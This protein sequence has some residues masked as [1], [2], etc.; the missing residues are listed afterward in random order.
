MTVIAN[1]RYAYRQLCRTPGFAAVALATLAICIGANLAIFSIVDAI[2]LRPLPF[3]APDRLIVI[4][5]SYPLGGVERGYNSIANYF[6]RRAAIKAFASLAIYRDDN[7][8]VGASGTPK[9]VPTMRVSSE[10]FSMLGTPL[11]MGRSFT[12]AE[13]SLGSDQVVVITDSFWR[14]HFGN[15]PKVLGRSFLNDGIPVT[16]VGVLRPDFRFLS[17]TPEFYRP[18]SYAPEDRH[19]DRRHYNRWNMIARLAPSA[20]IADA[21]AQINAL[22]I[23]QT[24]DDA[25]IKGVGYR[26]TVSP[27]HKDHVSAVR[28]TLVMLQCGCVFLLLIGLINLANLLLVR[29]SGR[30]Q[31]MA[32]RQTLG[33]SWR[34]IAAQVAVETIG[35][36]LAGAIL[37]IFLG[38]FGINLIRLLGTDQLP[39][40]RLITFD[41]HIVIVAL[42]AAAVVGLGLAIPV[43]WFALHSP[44]GLRL[45][46]T[47]G[48]TADRAAQSL[49]HGFIVVQIAL[50]FVLLSGAGLLGLTLK[51]LLETPLGFRAE[52]I[53]TGQIVLPQKNYS[54]DGARHAFVERLLPELRALPGVTEVAISTGLP[55]TNGGSYMG[56]AVE[57]DST[58]SGKPLHA[59]YL[60]GVSGEYWRTM[61]I[62]L[63]VG[64]ALEDTEDV[65]KPKVCVVDQSVAQRYWPG[66]SPIGRRLSPGNIF[67][68]TNAFTV[69]GVVGEVKQYEVAA[70]VGHGSIYFTY[71]DHTS[72]SFSVTLRTSLK[73]QSIASMLEKTVARLD[74]ELPIDH[75]VTM[76]AKVDQSLVTRRT[77]VM[78][79][80]TFAAVALLLAAV[81]TYG[82]IAYAV[83]QRRREIGIRMALGAIPQQISTQFLKLGL[84]LLA[85]GIALGVLGSWFASRAMQSLILDSETLHLG[86]LSGTTSLMLV[87]VLLAMLFP[88]RRA[89][90]VNPIEALRTE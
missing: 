38:Y 5:K 10:F 3:Y 64:R 23:E 27:L 67:S 66:N 36:A 47:R 39:L 18:S 49:R 46:K 25:I 26:S 31:E 9:R 11:A 86:V 51:R 30:S 75:V 28:P 87:V 57:G 73:P 45:Q 12:D 34:I 2:L 60:S 58:T 54:D 52:N 70:K 62:P 78:L 74:P 44:L 21:Q 6:D 65:R 48:G 16:V 89:A 14:S 8:I 24:A 77:S 56:I 7:A 4:F 53:L 61:S 72:D 1:I 32:I 84:K 59:H 17:S 55:F 29:A 81:G 71:A 15:D 13:L 79:I 83:S 50:A 35:L 37:G 80:G 69:V 43:V 76:Q 19:S 88:S 82:V 42:G 68:E 20:T 40:G 85:G 41:F 63:L 90:R 22:D 33:A